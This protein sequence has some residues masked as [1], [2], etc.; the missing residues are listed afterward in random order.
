M[1][2]D[3]SESDFGFEGN[4]LITFSELGFQASVVLFVMKDI[5]LPMYPAL[6]LKREKFASI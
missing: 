4:K 6:L 2:A 3:F 5:L 1:V